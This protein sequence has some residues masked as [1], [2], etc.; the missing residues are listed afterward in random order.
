MQ[1]HFL[2][3]RRIFTNIAFTPFI[4]ISNN[5]ELFAKYLPNEASQSFK[6]LENN[7]I[8]NDFFQELEIKKE[9]NILIA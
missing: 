4:L 9:K 1:K 6:G 8:K 5:S 2:K 7:N 3:Y